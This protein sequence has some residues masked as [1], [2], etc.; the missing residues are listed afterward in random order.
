M[1]KRNYLPPSVFQDEKQNIHF[2]VLMEQVQTVLQQQSGDLWTDVTAHDPGITLLEALAYNVSDLAYRHLLPL[3]DL[4]TPAGAQPDD[5]LFPPGFDAEQMLTTSPITAE[6][7]RKG[8]LDLYYRDNQGR[9]VYYF[10]DAELLKQVGE[11][12]Y[13]YFYNSEKRAFFFNDDGKEESTYLLYL[14]GTYHVRVKANYLLRDFGVSDAARL[15]KLNDYLAQHRNL[16]EQF[17]TVELF[18]ESSHYERPL[19]LEITSSAAVRDEDT[20]SLFLDIFLTAQQSLYP[21]GERLPAIDFAQLDYSGPRPQQGWILDYPPP[22]FAKVF[23]SASQV[24]RNIEALPG[25]AQVDYISFALE[26][27]S[28]I[29]KSAYYLNTFWSKSANSTKAAISNMVKQVTIKRGEKILAGNVDRIYALLQQRQQQSVQLPTEQ[30]L[31]GRYRNTARYYPASDLLPA[32]YDLQQRE[33]QEK[34]FQLHQFL[35]PFEQQLADGCAQLAHLPALLNFS[36]FSEQPLWGHQWPFAADSVGDE[37]HSRPPVG[38]GYKSAAI[39]ADIASQQNI[40]QQIALASYLQRYFGQPNS[41]NIGLS[42]D[43][44]FLQ[45]QRAYLRSLP[46]TGYAR[47]AIHVGQISSL[48]RRVAARLGIGAELFEEVSGDNLSRLPFYIIEHPLLMPR[49]PGSE[50]ITAQPVVKAEHYPAADDEPQRLVITAGQTLTDKLQAGQLIDLLLDGEEGE[51]LTAIL[52]VAVSGATFTLYIDEHEQLRLR[53]AKALEAAEAGQ[54]QWRTSNLWLREMEYRLILAEQGN[55]PAGSMRITT[56]DDQ[57]WP[58]TLLAGDTL[59]LERSFMGGI[60][61]HNDNTVF[62]ATVDSVDAIRGEAVITLADATGFDPAARYQWFIRQGAAQKLDR[63]SFT[64]SFVF[65]RSLIMQG[66]APAV[67]LAERETRIKRI[68]QE[69][70][71]AHLLARVLWLT[72]G[73]DQQFSVF[74]ATYAR[75]Q[76]NATRLGADAYNLLRMLSIG[77]LPSLATGIGVMHIA[78]DDE[79]AGLPPANPER[80]QYIDNFGLS[81][82]PDMTT[83]PAKK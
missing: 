71:P 25:I 60:R 43:D 18:G 44:E 83:T 16:C 2:D 21:A 6:D 35:L 77:M 22:N 1:S 36:A 55:L 52:V 56:A 14:N 75:W 76:N 65:R 10:S 78:T 32:L 63:F 49:E 54:L 3:V 41:E 37:V 57:P 26:S 79:F 66:E 45:V 64:L 31:V 80:Q 9:G 29:V 59:Q 46:E 67:S 48:Q 17:R 81:F 73:P 23:I 12:R 20:D 50:F 7:Y 62:T 61:G 30:F 69:E 11:D 34:P 53:W 40:P 15:A 70:I 39:A 33:P 24:K 19:V 42:S 47:T 82:V 13:R 68:I 8:I 27:V 72:D 74:G 58:P 5:T 38:D 28:W 4:L 51:I